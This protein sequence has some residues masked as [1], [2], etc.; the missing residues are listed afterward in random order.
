MPDEF[1]AFTA[2]AVQATP[3]FLDREATIDKACQLVEQAGREGARLIVF[4][5]TWVPTYPFW[6]M[7][8]PDAWLELYRNAVEVPS[9]ATRASTSPKDAEGSPSRARSRAPPVACA[10]AKPERAA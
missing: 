2:A 3:V 5:E 7:R 4:P 10:V 6:D 8:R 1:P 9:P